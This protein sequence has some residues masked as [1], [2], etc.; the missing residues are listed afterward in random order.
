MPSRPLNGRV[1]VKSA[2][3]KVLFYISKILKDTAVPWERAS[4]R[5]WSNKS[6][7]G[8]INGRVF[9]KLRCKS[10]RFDCLLQVSIIGRG[11]L[12]MS[13]HLYLGDLI[14]LADFDPHCS[15]LS[16]FSERSDSKPKLFSQ[17]FAVAPASRCVSWLLVSTP[18]EFRFRYPC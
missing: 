3:F 5:G 7:Q 2:P 17:R 8:A 18:R 12:L 4:E 11:R 14:R 10:P 6:H 15:G 9:V 13:Y 1:F 16:W